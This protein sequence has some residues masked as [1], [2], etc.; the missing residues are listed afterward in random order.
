LNVPAGFI[1]DTSTNAPTVLIS[2]LSG[3]GG[4]ANNINGV[5][6]GTAVAMTSVTT[7]QLVFTVTNSSINAVTCGL[8]W[9]N[10]RVRPT[11]G[12]PLATGFLTRSGG[13]PVAGLTTNAN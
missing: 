1:F 10:V 9:Q 7:T 5:S 4:S 2:R 13:A 6:S 8:T 11:A 12:T 3:S